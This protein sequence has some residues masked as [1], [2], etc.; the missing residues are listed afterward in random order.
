M[1][2]TVLAVQQITK[3]GITPAFTAANADGH[4]ILNDGL[5][6]L[7][8]KNAG[9]EMTVTIATP[10]TVDGLA[11]ADRVVTVPLTT[12]DKMIGPFGTDYNQA[13][14]SGLLVTFSRVSDVT[15]G[16]FRV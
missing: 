13:D 2:V 3:A 6:F 8:V 10:Q 1:A 7:E 16:A 4:S 15:C 12:G 5:T 9:A 14:G 11:V